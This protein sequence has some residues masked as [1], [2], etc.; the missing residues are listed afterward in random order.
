[1][2]F[3]THLHL[4]TI[5]TLS[6]LHP[7]ELSFYSTGGHITHPK[8]TR[9]ED[10]KFRQCIFCYFGIISPWKR[11]ESQSPKD[12]LCQ[13]WL[14][15]ASWFWRWKLFINVFLLFHNYLPLDPSLELTWITF[16][17]ESFVPSLI[18]KAHLNLR[19]R[20]AKNMK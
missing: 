8:N 12:A 1:M 7:K 4:Q 10:F 13:V 3:F 5:I 14:K 9:E 6:K 17:Q 20:W 2:L 16:T 11:A 18:R 15:L 19:L